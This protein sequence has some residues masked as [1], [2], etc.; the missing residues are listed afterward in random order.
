VQNDGEI[1]VYPNPT[2]QDVTVQMNLK[3]KEDIEITLINL[4]GQTLFSESLRNQTG[5]V[6]RHISLSQLTNAT[7]ILRVNTKDKVY[8]KKIVKLQ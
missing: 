6:Q 2:A 7:Y 4:L 1:N 3:G 8:C 5:L